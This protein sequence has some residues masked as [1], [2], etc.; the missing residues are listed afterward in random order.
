MIINGGVEP[1]FKITMIVKVKFCISLDRI[2]V[3]HFQLWNDL[4]NP[5]DTL[6]VDGRLFI[7]KA[8]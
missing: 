4:Q 2:S 3:N 7:L 1:D 5:V 8:I 6:N